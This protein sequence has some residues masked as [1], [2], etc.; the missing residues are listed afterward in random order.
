MTF[1]LMIPVVLSALL[2]L[3][4]TWLRSQWGVCSL[5]T[6][7]EGK[8][9]LVT[10]GNVGLGAAT[11]LDLAARGATVV[12]AARSENSS[13]ET[14]SRIR[15]QTGNS[16]VHYLHLD[17]A[18]F[19]SVRQF[20]GEF[21]QKYPDLY[22]LVCNA[23]VAFQMEKNVKT[24]LGLEIH[25]AVNHLGHFL[26]ANLL[27]DSFRPSSGA[28][29]VMVGSHLAGQGELDFEN[30]DHFK[31]GRKPKTKTIAPSGYC[32]S[33]LMNILFCKELVARSRVTAV[34]VCPGWCRTELGRNMP[35]TK[36]LRKCLWDL[37]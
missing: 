4:R 12:L 17:L 26:L 22:C 16:E 27:L 19:Q 2:Y 8:V 33:K 14:V 23:G 20:A 21:L 34:S 10:G 24:S 32:D 11:A 18:S 9:V 36:T 6:R 15:R 37:F 30:L 28:R 5:P 35:K 13:L 25:A 3:V 7:L 31:E 29:I 1:F